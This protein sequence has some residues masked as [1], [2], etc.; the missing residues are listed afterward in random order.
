[1]RRRILRWILVCL[2]VGETAGAQEFR[3]WNRS[4]QVHGFASQGFVYTS[5][6]NW[7]TMN[8]VDGSGA[9]TDMGLNVSSQ[10]SDRLRV[11]AQVYDYNLGQLGQWHPSL[12]WAVADYRFRDAF[13][14]RAGKVKTTLGLYND[15]QDLEFL[16]VFAL[17]PQGVYPTDV[18]DTTIAHTGGDLYGTIPLRHGLGEIAYTGYVGRRGDSIYGGY[19]FLAREWG[20][21]MKS[22][23]GLQ[24]GGDLRWNTPVRNLLIGTS[25]LNQHITVKGTCVSLLQPEQ[26]IVPYDVSTSPSWTN[27]FYAEYLFHRLKLDAEYRRYYEGMP[28]LENSLVKTDVHAW[29]VAGE[30]RLRKNLEIGSY[31]SHYTITYVVEGAAAI[32]SPRQ[33]DVGLPN[34]HIYDKVVA[35]RFDVNRFVY[36]KLEG[37]FMDGYGIGPYPNGFYPRVNPDDL[38]NNTNALVVKMGFHF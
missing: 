25:R 16:H 5:K 9:M 12:D 7:L 27:Q 13:G 33:T 8:T 3:L 10:L 26:G 38:Q 37:H 19:G 23:G 36:V 14:I 18:R 1:M 11:G 24:Y 22:S 17:L 34:N 20:V 2:C 28:Y 4:V 30:Y 32:L 31:Y 21:T 15:S 29:Y 6:N 35:A